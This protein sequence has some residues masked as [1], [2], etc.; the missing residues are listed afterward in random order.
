M[1]L[2][3]DDIFKTQL[4]TLSIGEDQMKKINLVVPSGEHIVFLVRKAR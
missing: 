3:I 1:V 2:K 4:L